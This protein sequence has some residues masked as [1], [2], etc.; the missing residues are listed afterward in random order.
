MQSH[1]DASGLNEDVWSIILSFV[2]LDDA[3]SLSLTS[4][5]IHPIAR[6]IVLS[7]AETSRPGHF[8][9]I[10][11]FMLGD[12]RSRASW[13]RELDVTYYALVDPSRFTSKPLCEQLADLL[14]AARNLRI[15]HLTSV[16]DLLAVEPRIGDAL[17]SLEGLKHINFRNISSGTLYVAEQMRSRPTTVALSFGS[18]TSLL[19]NLVTLSHLDLLRDVHTVGLY[20]LPEP[21]RDWDLAVEH[22]ALGQLGQLPAVRE[23]RLRMCEPLPLFHVFPNMQTLRADA[24]L[25]PLTPQKWMWPASVP[26]VDVTISFEDL[27]HFTRAPIRRLYLEEYSSC[28]HTLDQLASTLQSARPICLSFAFYGEGRMENDPLRNWAG[29]FQTILCSQGHL[30]YLEATFDCTYVYGANSSS[31]WMAVR[32]SEPSHLL[33]LMVSPVRNGSSR[34][35]PS[36]T[37]TPASY[38]C[39]STSQ[40]RS[41]AEHMPVC[42]PS[43]YCTRPYNPPLNEWRDMCLRCS[44]YALPWSP[45]SLRIST[46]RYALGGACVWMQANNV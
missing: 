31:P 32:P 20:S 35:L 16:D 8:R 12:S 5:A 28:D 19:D 46:S 40:S 29:V 18:G 36:P 23:A 1:R 42:H 27:V 41:T 4:R 10:C 26:L 45:T 11:T 37:A 14:G 25:S 21:S 3:R 44:T 13:L 38:V 9:K 43:G 24:E 30:R 22:F 2:Q 15:L 17:I 6:C 39:D 34:S 33:T 7:R